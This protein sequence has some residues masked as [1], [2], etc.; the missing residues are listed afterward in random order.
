MIM[1]YAEFKQKAMREDK[2][3]VFGECDCPE[4]VPSELREFYSK[5]NPV[6]VEISFPRLGA[7]RLY[8]AD[9]LSQL[10][11]DY[12]LGDENFV[13]A[14]TN[15]DAIF[16]NGGKVYCTLHGHYIPELLAETFDKFIELFY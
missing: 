6:D 11:A 4:I 9:E 13:F 1:R 10:Q 12:G 5:C 8:P 15:G 2:R 3:N 14:T 7:V 16:M